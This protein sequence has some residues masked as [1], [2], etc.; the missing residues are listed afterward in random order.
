MVLKPLI[1]TPDI[2]PLVCNVGFSGIR[3]NK[4]TRI[5]SHIFPQL[6]TTNSSAEHLFR[7]LTLCF[8]A[9]V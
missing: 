9:Q 7:E 5:L 4:N 6:F 2:Q 8:Y 1:K 3:Q